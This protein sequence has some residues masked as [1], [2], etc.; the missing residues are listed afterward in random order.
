MEENKNKVKLIKR[1]HT[2]KKSNKR[3]PTILRTIIRLFN[4]MK[5]KQ[6]Y[7]ILACSPMSPPSTPKPSAP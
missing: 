2:Q 4:K 5:P 3:N 6:L 7:Y 1:K